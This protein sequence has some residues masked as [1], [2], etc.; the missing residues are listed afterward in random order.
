MMDKRARQPFE[1][2]HTHAATSPISP[3][4]VLSEQPIAFSDVFTDEQPLPEPVEV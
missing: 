4:V 1:I 3:N 2:K